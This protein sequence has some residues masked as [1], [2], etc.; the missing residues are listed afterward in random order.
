[1]CPNIENP[2]FIVD[3]KVPDVA[4]VFSPSFDI[5][6]LQYVLGELRRIEFAYLG[7]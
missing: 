7:P 6:V 4:A 5:L 2:G 3:F 1:M